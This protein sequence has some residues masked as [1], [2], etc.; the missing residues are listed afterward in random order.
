MLN[1]YVNEY[2]LSNLSKL[3][4]IAPHRASILIISVRTKYSLLWL[5]KMD[6][7]ILHAFSKIIKAK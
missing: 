3:Q 6:D 5:Y 1:V 7:V 2:P 4:V